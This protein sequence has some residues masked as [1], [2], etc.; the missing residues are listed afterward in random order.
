MCVSRYSESTIIVIIVFRYI[1]L[2]GRRR[3]PTG[4]VVGSAQIRIP[5]RPPRNASDTDVDFTIR[6]AI[7]EWLQAAAGTVEGDGR[8]R[9]AG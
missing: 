8:E 3:V 5:Y 2:P 1:G 4:M 7:G 6:R 9:W